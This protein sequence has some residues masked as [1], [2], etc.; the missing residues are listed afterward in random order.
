[1]SVS[2]PFLAG[3]R[4]VDSIT[5]NPLFLPGH[6]PVFIPAVLATGLTLMPGTVLGMVASTNQLTPCVRTATDGSQTPYAVLCEPANTTA[7]G[8]AGV[9]GPVSLG[10]CVNGYFNASA[11]IIDTSFGV[12]PDLAF[13]AIE[14]ALRVAG[15]FGRFP[16]YSG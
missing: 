5:H 2:F 8:P 16:G 12:G 3:S 7:T 10:V 9:A 1:M 11:L 14:T 6:K 4:V 13:A 15:I